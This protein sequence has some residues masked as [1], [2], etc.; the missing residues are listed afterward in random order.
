MN[1]TDSVEASYERFGAGVQFRRVG[2][3]REHIDTMNLPTR[4]TKKSDTR[5][6]NFGDDRSVELN[7][8][9]KTLAQ[10]VEKEVRQY[11]DFEKWNA[12]LERENIERQKIVAGIANN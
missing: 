4:P 3:N 2:L 9:K 1:I 12:G 5:S 11:I 8:V 7:T 10:W 6:K